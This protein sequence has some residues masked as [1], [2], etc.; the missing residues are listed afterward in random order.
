M[1]SSACHATFAG[2]AKPGL[3]SIFFLTALLGFLMACASK[4]AARPSSSVTR[5]SFVLP[6]SA[7][8]SDDEFTRALRLLGDNCF[9]PVDADAAFEPGLHLATPRIYRLRAPM[10]MRL[11]DPHRVVSPLENLASL[12]DIEGARYR[13]ARSELVV[14]GPPAPAPGNGIPYND[15]LTVFRAISGAGVIGVSI[16]PGPDSNEMQVRYLGGIDGTHVGDVLFEAD[17]T[18]KIMS[19]GFDNDTCE[20]WPAMPDVIQTELDLISL[21]AGS[22]SSRRDGW[23]RFWFMPSEQAVHASAT[24]V[25][26]PDQRV[27]VKE[28]SVPAGQPSPP[29]AV[30]FASEITNNFLPLRDSISS[31]AD[32]HRIAGLVVLAQWMLEKHIPVDRA[33]IK[34]K[35]ASAYTPQVTRRVAVIRGTLQD[36]VFSALRLEGGVDFQTHY[37]FQEDGQLLPTFQSALAQR[38]RSSPTWDFTYKGRDYRAV[39][40]KYAHPIRMDS[41]RLVWVRSPEVPIP[42]LREL[43]FPP[44]RLAGLGALVVNNQTSQPLRISLTGRMPLHYAVAPHTTS[45]ISLL[46]GSYSLSATAECGTRSTAVQMQA[47]TIHREQYWCETK[48]IG[49]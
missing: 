21:E 43:A 42:Q 12:E 19:T 30:Q 1:A 13:P 36:H 35:A 11:A 9:S 46:P 31:F 25:R 14:I 29:S 7:P 24:T 47:G 3:S 10:V 23:H 15:W 26:I 37:R 38:P 44:E 16:D 39:S 8:V 40:L 27:V 32:L 5:P 18:M 6:V 4:E 45:T 34:T 28:E 17:R 20:K 48:I 22:A 33:W 49:H 2:R 41:P